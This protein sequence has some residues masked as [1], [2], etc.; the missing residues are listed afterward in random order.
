MKQG[1]ATDLH[2]LKL[3]VSDVWLCGCD[4]PVYVVV[5]MVD[6]PRHNVLCVSVSICHSVAALTAT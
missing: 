4:I 1:R 6:N 3:K 2:P 5:L